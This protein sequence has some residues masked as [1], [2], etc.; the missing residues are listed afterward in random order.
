M[1]FRNCCGG[2][3]EVNFH[4]STFASG[5]LALPLTARL[6]YVLSFH[7]VLRSAEDRGCAYS[8]GRSRQCQLHMGAPGTPAHSAASISNDP[9]DLL[10][11][12]S[13]W[14]RVL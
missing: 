13:N 7:M 1:P 10:Q 14:F 2:R 3:L 5:T 8:T 11:P 4:G 9:A 12:R 6:T